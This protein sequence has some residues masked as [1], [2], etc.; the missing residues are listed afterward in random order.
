MR[1]ALLTFFVGLAASSAQ[2]E[3]SS[4]QAT[5]AT[6][7]PR[8]NCELGPAERYFDGVQWLVF[9]CDDGASVVVVT[10]P[11]SPKDLNFYFIVF[12]KD[13]AYK[14]HGEGNGNR[15]LTRPAYEAL[16]AMTDGEL[17]A[18]HAE[19][20]AVEQVGSSAS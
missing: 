16:S 9:A 4:E 5:A 17:R 6:E 12:P 11:K 3:P 13:G 18:L 10:G 20:T 8:L 19:A 7:K 14:L 1:A 2:A 15:A